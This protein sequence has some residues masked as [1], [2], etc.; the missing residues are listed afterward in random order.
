MEEYLNWWNWVIGFDEPMAFHVA[1]SFAKFHSFWEVLLGVVGA[2]R[3]TLENLDSHVVC[4]RVC[5]F[6]YVVV[7]YVVRRK[8]AFDMI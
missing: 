7:P 3:I 5:F 1:V 8:T 6:G 4:S 2:A